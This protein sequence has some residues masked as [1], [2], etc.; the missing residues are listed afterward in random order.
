[1]FKQSFVDPAPVSNADIAPTLAQ[2]LGLPLPA[3]GKL[4][5]RVAIEA[6]NGGEPVSYIRRDIVSAPSAEGLRTI[7]NMQY[8]GETP[9]F[10]AAGFAGRTLGLE[11][12]AGIGIAGVVGAAELNPAAVDATKPDQLKWRDPTGQAD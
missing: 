10:D 9:Y 1:A 7:V 2:V 3:T 5:G 11:V 12:P 6:L 8:V 4:M